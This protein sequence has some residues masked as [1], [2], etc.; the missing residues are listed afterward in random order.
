MWNS[1]LPRGWNKVREN[2]SSG[3]V[4]VKRTFHSIMRLRQ[5]ELAKKCQ[6]Q[7]N[8]GD[9][10]FLSLMLRMR[11]WADCCE[12]WC[13][14]VLMVRISHVRVR[15]T[16]TDGGGGAGL[17]LTLTTDLLRQM[18]HWGLS[19]S[20]QVHTRDILYYTTNQSDQPEHCTFTLCHTKHQT[21]HAIPKH[22]ILHATYIYPSPFLGR[23]TFPVT[24]DRDVTTRSTSSQH[25]HQPA[26][27]STSSPP[28]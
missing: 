14:D 5:S 8:S 7:C 9:T 11:V 12:L 24:T 4:R 23:E 26:S 16:G 27:T 25:H 28:T 18:A 6:A 21:L 19:L 17:Q 3:P 1:A 15:V 20:H 2:D 10:H 13:F 22:Y